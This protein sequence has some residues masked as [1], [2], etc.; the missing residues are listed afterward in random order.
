MVMNHPTIEL[1]KRI[2]YTDGICC[3]TCKHY[4]YKTK[5]C[6]LHK[7]KVQNYASCNFIDIEVIT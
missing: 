6:D 4:L 5:S 2:N 7:I 3:R 1:I